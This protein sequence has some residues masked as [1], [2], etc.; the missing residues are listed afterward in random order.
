MIVKLE[1]KKKKHDCKDL[2]GIVKK[3]LPGNLRGKCG[4]TQ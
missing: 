2:S 3:P 1:R 4:H